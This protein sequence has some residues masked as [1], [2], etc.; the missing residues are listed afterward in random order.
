MKKFLIKISLFLVIFTLTY[1]GIFYMIHNGIRKSRYVDYAEWNEIYNG[2]INADVLIMGSSRAWHHVDPHLVDSSLNMESYNMG[3]DG[4]HFSMQI[5]KYDIYRNYNIKPTGIIYIVDH[6]SFDKRDDLFNKYQFIP[7]F[8]DTIIT[9]KL[10][11]YKGFSWE[12][13][14]IPFYQYSGSQEICLAGLVEFMGIKS[15][16][17]DKYKGFRAENKNWESNFDLEKTENPKGKY[18]SVN[19]E[20]VDELDNFLSEVKSEGIEIVM[21]YAPEYIEFQKYVINRDQIIDLYEHLARKNDIE[22]IDYSD[23]QICLD[24]QYFYDPVHMNLKGSNIFTK[25][26]MNHLK[27][28]E[29]ERK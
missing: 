15:F 20:V 10:K 3:I 5:T 26:L 25:D 23:H 6:F 8:N 29:N 28:S 18:A 27:K 24:K 17:S 9:N 16:K 11:E 14:N 21:V 2:E 7:Y 22:F 19:R 4:Y 12:H 1:L 13:F